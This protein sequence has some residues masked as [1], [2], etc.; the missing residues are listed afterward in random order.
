M[1]RILVKSLFD[2]FDYVADY[3]G[4]ETFA[5]IS[6]QDAKNGGFGVQF[7]PTDHCIDV[8]TLQFD[9]AEVQTEHVTLFTTEQAAQI[10][11][12]IRRNAHRVDTLLVHCYAGQSRSM[13]VGAFATKMLGGDDSR[14]FQRATPNKWVYQ[15]LVDAWGAPRKIE[16]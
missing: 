12:F 7:V 13:A 3:R 14:Y 11:K 4:D 16:K 6:I 9:D 1:K 8:L 10:I 15:T 5:I 2:C